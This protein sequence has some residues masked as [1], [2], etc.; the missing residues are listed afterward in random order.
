MQFLA[1]YLARHLQVP[2]HIGGT[3]PVAQRHRGGPQ[4]RGGSVEILAAQLLCAGLN[5]RASRDQAGQIRLSEAGCDVEFRL[6]LE[7]TVNHAYILPCR[8]REHYVV[9][10]WTMSSSRPMAASRVA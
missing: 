10:A 9:P 1:P 4:I 6:T 8:A 2:S 3:G 7:V 5:V